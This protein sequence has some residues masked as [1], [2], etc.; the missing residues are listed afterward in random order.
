[1]HF[2]LSIG[3]AELDL[4]TVDTVAARVGFMCTQCWWRQWCVQ[5]RWKPAIG[6]SGCGDGVETC[7]VTASGCV[8]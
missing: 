3:M 1:M 6:A 7:A 2:G 8:L 5:M 4:E